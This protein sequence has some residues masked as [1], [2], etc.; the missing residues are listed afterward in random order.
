MLQ[1]IIRHFKKLADIKQPIDLIKIL[2]GYIIIAFVAVLP[3]IIANIGFSQG[4][5]EGNSGLVTIGWLALITV[6]V[7]FV[8]AIIWTVV[9]IKNIVTFVKNS[10]DKKS[11]DT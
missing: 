6:P 9:A 8:V 2:F 5:H 3:F 4:G 10:Q 7:G 11:L 1:D